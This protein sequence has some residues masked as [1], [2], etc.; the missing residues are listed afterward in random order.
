MRPIKYELTFAI[1][2]FLPSNFSVKHTISL[3]SIYPIGTYIRS[4]NRTVLQ[5][6]IYIIISIWHT[7]VIFVPCQNAE[8]A[9]VFILE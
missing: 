6:V 7:K 9:R 4:G 5:I 3:F 2:G 1:N 8:M